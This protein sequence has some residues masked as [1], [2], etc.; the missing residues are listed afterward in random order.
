MRSVRAKAVLLLLGGVLFLGLVALAWAM[1]AGSSEAQQGAMHNCPQAGKWAISVWSGQDGTDTGEALATCGTVPVTAAYYMDPEKGWLGYFDGFT[2][3]SNLLTLND[4]QGIIALGSAPATPTSL[5][6]P[7]ATYTGTTSQDLLIEF[8]VSADGSTITRLIY[9]ISG[10]LP[11]GGT[12]DRFTI[13]TVDA[14]IEDNSFSIARTLFDMSGHFE[15]QWQATGELTVHEPYSDGVLP[16]NAGPL[17][18]TATV[19]SATPMPTPTPPSGPGQLANCPQ[20]GKWAI[21]VWDGPNGTETGQALA[22]C[23]TVPVT[24]AYYMDPEKGWLGYF[25]EHTDISKLLTLDYLQGIIVLG[26]AAAP[27][28]TPTATPAPGVLSAKE[29]YPLALQ[30]AR[31]GHPDA[32]LYEVQSGCNSGIWTRC[33]EFEYDDMASGDGRSTYWR[34]SFYL[35]GAN[36]DEAGFMVD[37]DRGQPKEGYTFGYHGSAPTLLPLEELIDSTEAVQIADARGGSAYKAASPGNQLCGAELRR[38]G[39]RGFEWQI[40]YCPPFEEGGM[41]LAVY[42]DGRTG[43]LNKTEEPEWG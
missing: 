42:L 26:G 10:T 5:A 12:C 11:G 21:S 9:K 31:A 22:T 8:E 15:T 25:A 39:G 29:G 1:S 43:E 7:G 37:V 27:T 35:P 14:P 40:D 2:D 32:Y 17:T 16:C 36:E 4:K 41:G 13:P 33:W 28:P 24:A 18:W 3:I 19:P 6:I 20:A 30:V 34:F 23:G 38:R